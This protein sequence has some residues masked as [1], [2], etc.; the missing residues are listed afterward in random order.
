MTAR[1]QRSHKPVTRQ[2]AAILFARMKAKLARRFAKKWEAI[3]C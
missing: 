3:S 1:Q 2:R